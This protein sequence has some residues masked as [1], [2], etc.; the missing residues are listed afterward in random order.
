MNS[1]TVEHFVIQTKG[2]LVSKMPNTA[3]SKRA[4]VQDSRHLLSQ[5]E[6]FF[7]SI[8]ESALDAVDVFML[9]F[10]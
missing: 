1:K 10:D 8:Q 5:P 4:L 9:L 2:I 3:G 7:G 6:I